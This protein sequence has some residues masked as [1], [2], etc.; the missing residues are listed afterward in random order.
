MPKNFLLIGVFIVILLLL[1]LLFGWFFTKVIV[2]FCEFVGKKL[3]KK[4]LSKNWI[5]FLDISFI[6]L[7]VSFATIGLYLAPFSGYQIIIFMIVIL[8]Y[9]S[10]IIIETSTYN[11]FRKRHNISKTSGIIGWIVHRPVWK[12]YIAKR[13]LLFFE[14]LAHTF[15]LIAPLFISYQIMSILKWNDQDYFYSLLFLPIYANVWVYLKFSKKYEV[16][17]GLHRSIIV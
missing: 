9:T 14:Q 8:I 11:E 5:Y 16:V 7:I 3:A 1:L 12:T 4:L 15:Y 6:V 2:P 10:L 13:I 17:T